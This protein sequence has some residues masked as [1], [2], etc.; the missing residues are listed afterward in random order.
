MEYT[1]ALRH[2]QRARNMLDC[3]LSMC[4]DKNSS[5]VNE[6]SSV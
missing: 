6:V 1:T 5:T 3:A 4:Q 2:F